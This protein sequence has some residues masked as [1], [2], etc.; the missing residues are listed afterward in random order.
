MRLTGAADFEAFYFVSDI[1]ENPILCKRA[2]ARLE[3]LLDLGHG[4]PERAMNYIFSAYLGDTLLSAALVT[5]TYL[6]RRGE[7]AGEAA[8]IYLSELLKQLFQDAYEAF[9]GKKTVEDSTAFQNVYDFNLMADQMIYFSTQQYQSEYR[10]PERLYPDIPAVIEIRPGRG[11][12]EPRGWDIAEKIYPVPSRNPALNLTVR[13]YDL[14]P[15]NGPNPLQRLILALYLHTMRMVLAGNAVAGNADLDILARLR[16]AEDEGDE[17]LAEQAASALIIIRRDG[18]LGRYD[19]NGKQHYI[20][21]FKAG[22]IVS[23]QTFTKETSGHEATFQTLSHEQAFASIDRL[24]EACNDPAVTR[25]SFLM[26]LLKDEDQGIRIQAISL[27]GKMGSEAMAAAPALLALK[28][29]QNPKPENLY[30]Y[31]KILDALMEIHAD[32]LDA[33][34]AAL[35][36]EIY[37]DE[38]LAV[39]QAL[40]ETNPQKQMEI[41]SEEFSEAEIQIFIISENTAAMKTIEDFITDLKSSNPIRI[42]QAAEALADMKAKAVPALMRLLSQEKDWWILERAL[43]VLAQVGPDTSAVLSMPD[44]SL[45]IALLGHEV[46]EVSAGAAEAL[47]SLGPA[48]RPALHALKSALQHKDYGVV[49]AAAKALIRIAP[50]TRELA[51]EALWASLEKLEQDTRWAIDAKTVRASLVT[52]YDQEIEKTKKALGNNDL[53][54]IQKYAIVESLKETNPEKRREILLDVFSPE[55]ADTI[56]RQSDDLINDSDYVERVFEKALLQMPARG[57]ESV[58]A[59]MALL[60]NENEDVKIDAAL[61]LGSIGLEAKEALPLLW[62]L[63]KALKRKGIMETDFARSIQIALIEIEKEKIDRAKEILGVEDLYL[64]KEMAILEAHQVESVLTGIDIID[65]ASQEG[66][67]REGGFSED[68]IRILMSKIF[69]K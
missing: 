44:F 20:I 3:R 36:R 40:Y 23:K 41:L 67:L 52:L 25:L 21:L 31:L 35:V 33:V 22:N 34:C 1:L 12:V 51:A 5:A 24:V 4:D 63:F 62:K 30:F 53:T 7:L 19:R 39:I 13:S 68:E 56:L 59:L 18:A 60:E 48:A 57:K 8:K 49:R 46:D 6:Q 11:W 26:G 64:E 42:K 28:E 55:E 32:T 66:L 38:R 15:V 65:I 14:G 54:F 10:I 43:M 61:T 29:F 9:S 17:I 58:P 47:G 2:D 45:L 27:L 69:K 37:V 16:K 50:E